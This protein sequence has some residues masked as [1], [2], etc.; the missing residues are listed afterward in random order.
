M[1]IIIQVSIR[2]VVLKLSNGPSSLIFN[3]HRVEKYGFELQIIISSHFLTR[4]CC[5]VN[6]MQTL[7]S[8]LNQRECPL[9]AEV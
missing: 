1:H 7:S 9:G 4:P 6:N 8:R 5:A 3:L 2:G